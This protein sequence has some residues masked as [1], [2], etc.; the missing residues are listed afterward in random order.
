MVFQ[1]LFR[2]IRNRKFYCTVRLTV[3]QWV[4]GY[5]TVR[6]LEALSVSDGWVYPS[7]GWG[8]PP[9][10]LSLLYLSYCTVRP[11][12]ALGLSDGWTGW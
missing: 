8:Y 9:S 2:A 7:D 1:Q 10:L 6:P 4:L 11:L 12:E 3:L 5:C